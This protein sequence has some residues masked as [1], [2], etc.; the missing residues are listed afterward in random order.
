M[1][2]ADMS[3]S[4]KTGA[5]ARA[6]IRSNDTHPCIGSS[7]TMNLRSN[8]ALAA[9][10]LGFAAVEIATRRQRRN[11]A[12]RDDLRLDLSTI[13]LLALIQP[14]IIASAVALSALALPGRHDAWAHLPVW[15]MVVALL[16][17]DDLTQYLWHR[18]S[19]TRWLWPLHRAHHTA[20][21]MSVRM[22]W[23]NNLF[24]YA[25]MPGLWLSGVLI[26]LG[27]AQAYVVYAVVK[28]TVIMGAHC[29]VPWDAPL[30]RIR[31]LRPLAW[32]LERTISTP[33][34]HRAHH[35]LTSDDGIGHQEG[36]FGNLLFV[37]DLLF[38][39]AKI[40]RR[41]PARVGLQDDLDFGKERWFV[42]AAWPLVQSR[43]AQS[44][45]VWR[46][47]PLRSRE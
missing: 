43:R 39:T 22:T 29:A 9:I 35:A 33:A 44:I 1:V 27:L 24:Y 23:R 7:A 37:W 5:A 20:H 38:G 30:H 15:A 28:L 14:L 11:A 13:A 16:L 40:T 10:V 36:N 18:A 4:F 46:A 3:Q 34:T 8:L 19:H 2:G 25:M 47:R 41:Y 21:Y 26:Y 31:A 42:E 32:V 12:S 17:G 6:T 45:L